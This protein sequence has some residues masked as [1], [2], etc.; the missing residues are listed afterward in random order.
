MIIFI[1]DKILG[2]YLPLGSKL[3]NEQVTLYNFM[4]NINGHNFET[5]SPIDFKYNQVVTF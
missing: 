2:I 4:T 5:K 3:P 1:S